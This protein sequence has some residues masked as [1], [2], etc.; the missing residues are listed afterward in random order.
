M[1]L[2]VAGFRLQMF[3]A[4]ADYK[5]WLRRRL[6]GTVWNRRGCRSWYRTEAGLSTTL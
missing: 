1:H 4:Q 5:A 3:E 6:A 2:S